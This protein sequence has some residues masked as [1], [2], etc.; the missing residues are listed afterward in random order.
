MIRCTFF[1][2]ALL[3]IIGFS[4][5]KQEPFIGKLV[6]SIE[7][8]DTNFR[9]LYPPK[10][11][12]VYSN[13]TITRIENMSD[14]LGKQVLLKH[15]VLNKSFLLIETP[16]QNFAI[17]TD[18]GDVEKKPS[19]YSFKKKMGK[20]KIADIKASR[21]LISHPDMK[22]NREFLYLKNYSPKYINA[23]EE[24]PGLPVLYY[25]ITEDGV[26][27]YTLKSIELAE[28]KRDLFGIPSDF[29]KVTMDEFMEYI[30]SETQAE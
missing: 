21:L 18:F 5:K 24:L 6:Y 17:K 4:Q 30:L 20:R 12:V 13:D 10:Q 23:F 29:K 1:L 16:G 25:I 2:L 26:F 28:P 9:E 14:Q 27:K 15:L 8:D 22:V 3:P 19:K 7:I 11:M